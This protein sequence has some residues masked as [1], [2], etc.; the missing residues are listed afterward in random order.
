MYQNT[1]AELKQLQTFT[2][3]ITDSE[4]SWEDKYA[5]VFSKHCSKRIY[6]LLEDLNLKLDYY[7]PDT[8]YEEDV[9]AYRDALDTR[10][11]NLAPALEALSTLG[12]C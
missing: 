2:Q 5:Q 9:C 4:L 3:N 8:S 12:P 7:D 6:A 11:E 10:M 1:I